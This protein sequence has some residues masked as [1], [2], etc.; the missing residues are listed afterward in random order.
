M[1]NG[2]MGASQRASPRDDGGMHED[3]RYYRWRTLYGSKYWPLDAGFYELLG[4]LHL[5]DVAAAKSQRVA[6]TI[7][8]IARKGV[9][10]P[11]RLTVMGFDVGIGDSK[12]VMAQRDDQGSW[13]IIDDVTPPDQQAPP[14]E[15]AKAVAEHIAKRVNS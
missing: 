6:E 7:D 5:G 10:F 3:F 4:M 1:G 9:T 13:V 2:G 11:S 8:L 14:G 15:I 12:T